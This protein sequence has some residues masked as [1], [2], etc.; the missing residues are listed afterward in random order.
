M[1]RKRQ[2]Y[3]GFAPGFGFYKLF[4]IFFIGS[5]LGVVIETLWCIITR[6]HFES[7]QG[8][9]YGP[10]NLVYGFGALLMTLGLHWCEHKNDR[11]VFVGGVLI[12]SVY[13]YFCSF[14]QEAMFGTVSW[15]YDH[16]PFNLHG[17]IN[18]LYSI[19]WGILALLWVKI[20][21]PM[22][23][24]WIARIPNRWWKPLTWVLLAFMIANTVISACAVGRMSARHYGA[25]AQNAFER[26][27]D[28][29]YTDELLKFVYPNMVY[30][31]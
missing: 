21:C 1:K 26:F 28:A 4:W 13:E 9:I 12:G 31:E 8:L 15:Q 3:E 5:F 23:S 30:T 10:F 22:M 18:L 27:L 14:L 2:E 25:P 24:R 20:L 17:R 19:F 6:G 11:W 29:H 7:R 16:L